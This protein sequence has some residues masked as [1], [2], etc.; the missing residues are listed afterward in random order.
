MKT[1]YKYIDEK[2]EHLHTLDS[3]PLIGTSSVVKTA[4]PFSNL[5]WASGMA[6]SIFGWLNPRYNTPEVLK[7]R[8]SEVLGEIKALDTESYMTLLEKAYK[9]HAEKRDL[10]AEGGKDLHAELE[11]YVKLCLASDGVPVSYTEDNP[12]VNGFVDW[13]ILNVEKFLGSETHTY[14]EKKWLGGI[15]DCIALM[16]DGKTA[17]FDFKSSKEAYDAHFFQISLYDIQLREKGGY[18][19]DGNK[20]L[21][22]IRADEYI[23]V[24]FG[25]T[26]FEPA[27]RFNTKQLRAV[28]RSLLTTYR[29]IKQI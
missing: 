9:A 10:A 26:K 17:I 16:K 4:F 24:P 5:Y 2:G 7:S 15:V 20:I 19:K 25:A 6:V 21:K 22:R 8:A 1:N 28:G 18:D 11:D 3:R 29:V 14:S 23:V 27:F 12:L 13:A